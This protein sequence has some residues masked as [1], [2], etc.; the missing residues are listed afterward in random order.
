MHLPLMHSKDRIGSY[1]QGYFIWHHGMPTVIKKQEETHPTTVNDK[2]AGY[3]ALAVNQAKQFRR[4]S[5]G[6]HQLDVLGEYAKDIEYLVAKYGS[7]PSY[8]RSLISALLPYSTNVS[9]VETIITRFYTS[10]P[11]FSIRQD[12]GVDLDPDQ[13]H[14]FWQYAQSMGYVDQTDAY[15]KLLPLR[16]GQWEESLK[17]QVEYVFFLTGKIYRLIADGQSEKLTALKPRI[18][19]LIKNL[20]IELLDRQHWDRAYAL[21]E[22]LVPVIWGQ[23]LELLVS[24]Y[25]EELKNFLEPINQKKNYQLGLYSEGYMDLLFYLIGGLDK[26]TDHWPWVF[27]LAKLLE[28]HILAGVE[29]RFEKNEYLLRLVE[30]YAR[31]KNM[32]EANRCFQIMLDYSMGPSWYKE[33]QLS[34]MNTTVRSALPEDHG[35]YLQRY[36]AHLHHASG[37]MTFQRYIKQG[38][39]DFVG[40]LA[41]AGHH[42]AA[43]A[44]LKYLVLPDHQTILENAETGFIDMPVKG[45]GYIL[46]ARA[47]EEQAGVLRLLEYTSISRS[48]AAWGLSE[49]WVVGDDRYMR[50]YANI[51]TTLIE[52]SNSPDLVDRL[53][54]FLVTEVDPEHRPSYIMALL[55]QSGPEPEMVLEAALK[56]AGFNLPKKAKSGPSG[57]TRDRTDPLDSLAEVKTKALALL[58]MGNKSAAAQLLIVSLSDIQSQK[59]SVWSDYYSNKINAVTELL[60]EVYDQSGV[61]IADIENLLIN[62]PYFEAWVVAERLIKLIGPIATD[63]E[64]AAIAHAVDEHVEYMVRTPAHTVARYQWLRAPNTAVNPVEEQLLELLIWFLN[65]PDLSVKN[66]TTEILSWLGVQSARTVVPVLV[67]SLFQPGYQLSNELAAAVLHQIALKETE[68]FWPVLNETLIIHE[69]ELKAFS[70]FSIINVLIEL[71]EMRSTLFTGQLAILY[72]KFANEQAPHHDVYFDE[73]HLEPISGYLDSL[74]ASGISNGKFAKSLTDRINDG[75]LITIEERQLASQYI[76]RSFNDFYGLQTVPDFE[77]FLRFCLNDTVTGFVTAND[78]KAVADILRFYQPTFPESQ[79]RIGSNRWRGLD[80]QIKSLALGETTDVR[81]LTGRDVLL[82][83]VSEHYD[84]DNRESSSYECISYLVP[85]ADWKENYRF[86]PKCEFLANML[87]DDQPYQNEDLC[88]PLV[89]ESYTVEAIGSDLIPSKTVHYAPENSFAFIRDAV[90][91][92]YWRDGRN[93]DQKRRGEPIATG[94]CLHLPK[95]KLNKLKTDYK[96]IMAVSY[97]YHYAHIDVFAQKLLNYENTK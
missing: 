28:V 80:S 22:T 71:L 25:P 5:I 83:Y 79:L 68:D 92:A 63:A 44:Y 41:K 55:D 59:Y 48:Q 73:D 23:L 16:R 42:S 86:Q 26:L 95:H 11:A 15:P 20:Q 70:H 2:S 54:K 35:H 51:Q 1:L 52:H 74:S 12:N 3:L 93:W 57:P 82:H 18:N 81:S 29:N 9:L 75:L 58:E 40:D 49:L 76:E 67:Q 17:R 4:L 46:G 7:V 89:T 32:D 47:I 45:Q 6:R 72:A 37:E 24:Y 88:I 27:K 91:T 13:I 62:E 65:H 56:K 33:S 94:Y 78:R 10:R 36:A 61:F 8:D 66:R 53:V 90:Q 96:L 21:P 87:P 38:Q 43:I 84:K 77:T 19:E 39:E 60:T 30:V 69:P 14:H 97:D 64:K 31:L 85:V 34:V 50:D